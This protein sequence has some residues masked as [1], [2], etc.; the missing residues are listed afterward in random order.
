MVG[1]NRKQDETGRSGV[2]SSLQL[3]HLIPDQASAKKSFM[4]SP[5][6]KFAMPIA[7]K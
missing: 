2:F 3:P 5:K 6:A 4:L 7:R 1:G